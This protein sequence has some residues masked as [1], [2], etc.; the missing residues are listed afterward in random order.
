VRID[1]DVVA[2]ASPGAAA[3]KPAGATAAPQAQPEKK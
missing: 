3:G 2:A 1:G